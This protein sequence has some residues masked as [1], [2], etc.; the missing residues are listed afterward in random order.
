MNWPRGG[1]PVRVAENGVGIGSGVR[2]LEVDGASLAYVVRG[3]GPGLLVPWC[4]LPWPELPLVDA[5]AERF[6]VVLASPRGYQF[7]SRLPESAKYDAELLFDDLLAVCDHVGLGGFSVLG[8]SLTAAMAA[9]LARVSDRVDA[10]VAG[11]FPLLGSYERVLRRAQRD[12]P[13]V[14]DTAFDTRAVLAFY[15][16]LAT[17]DDGALVRD[18]RC[19]VMAFWGTDDHLLESFNLVT[20]Y[21]TALSERG[22]ATVALRAHDHATAIVELN[23]AEVIDFLEG[24]L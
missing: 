2:S 17:L 7:S 1:Q 6:T 12:A 4:N 11:G 14:S 10:L 13:N 21:G 3:A 24:G 23:A 19:P 20:D 18:V 8:Y 15:R 9:S 22:V 16:Y 5:L